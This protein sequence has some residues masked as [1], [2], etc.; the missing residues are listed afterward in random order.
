[1]IF[2]GGSKIEW[3]DALNKVVEETGAIPL[4]NDNNWDVIVGQGTAI[5]EM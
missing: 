2:S 4:P 5:M 1:M 3:V